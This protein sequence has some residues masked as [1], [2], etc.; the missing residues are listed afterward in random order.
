MKSRRII[1]DVL[2][3][4]ICLLA[5]CVGCSKTQKLDPEALAR[6]EEAYP[7]IKSIMEK[8]GISDFEYLYP[9]DFVCAQFEQLTSREKWQ[10]IK[11]LS[12]VKIKYTSSD[13]YPSAINQPNLYIKKG[14]TSFYYYISKSSYST[15]R[16]ALSFAGEDP[17]QALYPGVYYREETKKGD[18]LN[19]TLVYRE[20]N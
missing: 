19:T 16:E 9:K 13:T 17:S 5:F 20:E 11:D 7:A 12:E 1:V 4:A 14:D 18:L 15:A 3:F 8:Y 2:L 6:K 10:L